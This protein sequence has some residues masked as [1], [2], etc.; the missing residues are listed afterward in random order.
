M[1]RPVRILTL[2]VLLAALTGLVLLPAEA[3]TAVKDGLRLCA[4][5]IIP[6]LFPFFVLSSMAVSL[7]LA[8]S[9]GT[10]LAP[11]MKPF[12]GVGRAGA[13]ALAL[14]LVGGY[15]VGAR[16]V[17]QL[18]E[19]G[20]CGKSEA[21]RLLGFCNNCGPAFIL[22]IAGA[23]IF[24]SLHAG[25]LLLAGHALG[26]VTN[27]ILFRLYGKTEEGQSSPV[28]IRSVTISGAFTEAVNSGLRS[29]LSVCAYVTLFSVLLRFLRL[30][31]IFTPF[32]CVSN[33]SALAVGFFELTS[34]MTALNPAC[35]GALPLCAFLLGFGG[36]SVL[37][38]TL[39]MLEGSGLDM[40]PI[41]LGKLLHGLTAA[42][43]TAFLALVFPLS[44]QTLAPAYTEAAHA[45]GC[46]PLAVTGGSW[47]AFLIYLRYFIRFDSRKKRERSV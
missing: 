44:A 9:V 23:G 14:G 2:F 45:A 40:R 5:V 8:R 29:T 4:G 35:P 6:A 20:Q 25:L 13:G 47:C 7:G 46:L 42:G 24:G 3:A 17:R 18:Y 41:L 32:E 16:T 11:I 27:G 26:A 33:G 21:E 37:C 28:A 38:Q 22:G 15:P 34:G 36:L 39:A 30:L 19:S 10:L 31:G 12:F 1:K 43:W